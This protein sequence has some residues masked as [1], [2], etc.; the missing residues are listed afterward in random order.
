M[1]RRR[2]SNQQPPHPGPLPRRSNW[3]LPRFSRGRGGL[4]RR[5]A[6]DASQERKRR[7]AILIYAMVAMLIA[8]MI[9]GAL[10]KTAL[11]RRQLARREQLRMQAEWLA[12][13]ALNRA[14]A[15]LKTDADYAGETWN[16][17]K[18]DLDGE[19][20][21]VVTIRVVKDS[22]NSNRRKVTATATWP[23]TGEQRAQVTR[24]IPIDIPTNSTE[25]TKP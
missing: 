12:E 10:V 8:T 11:A 21:A 22:N 4:F 25:T 19:H 13:S 17:P 7:G 2:D 3:L 14:A 20:D 5:C 6:S 23:A 1:R 16:I 15:K 18:T 9:G 24:T